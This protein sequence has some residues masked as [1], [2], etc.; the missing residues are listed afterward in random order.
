MA[1]TQ[2]TNINNNPDLKVLESEFKNLREDF[3][4]FVN[5]FKTNQM[6]R[7]EVQLRLA[8]INK[9]IA[10]IK[11]ELADHKKE[12]IKMETT[13]NNK[14]TSRNWITHTLT[15]MFTAI[16][17]FLSIYVISDVVTK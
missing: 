1:D 13:L 7:S 11:L 4:E 9:E 5:D 15:A 6:P 14:I 12:A 8:E 2:T 10:T 3:R 16:L 17:T